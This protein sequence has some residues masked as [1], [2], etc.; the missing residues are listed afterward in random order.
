MYYKN[1][2]II[3]HHKSLVLV[4]AIILF[5]CVYSVTSRLIENHDCYSQIAQICIHQITYKLK[6]VFLEMSHYLIKLNEFIKF[7]HSL[8]EQLLEMS[9]LL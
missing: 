5:I 8:E 6:Q 1:L 7:L 3:L 9:S 2:T 4:L